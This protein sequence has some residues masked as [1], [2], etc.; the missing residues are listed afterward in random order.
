MS[1]LETL[2]EASQQFFTALQKTPYA[3]NPA[4]MKLAQD[5]VNKTFTRRYI[6]VLVNLIYTGD[7]ARLPNLYT[8][9]KGF[10]Q[11]FPTTSF[12]AY[13][14]MAQV[15]E[16]VTRLRPMWLQKLLSKVLYYIVKMA[17]GMKN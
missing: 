15:V 4:N 6:R 2:T 12:S 7:T 16:I 3:K 13:N 10:L 5:Y 14:F 9:R 1:G 17:R 11:H 8:N